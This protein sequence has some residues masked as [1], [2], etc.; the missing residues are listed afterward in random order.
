MGL[1]KRKSHCL[2]RYNAD[3]CGY[4]LAGKCW[5]FWSNS[6]IFP[7][8]IFRSSTIESESFFPFLSVVIS[9]YQRVTYSFV[10][11]FEIT[12]SQSC[13]WTSSAA[14]SALDLVRNF[15]RL[16]WLNFWWKPS[17]RMKKGKLESGNSGKKVTNP[18]QAIAIGLSEAR[19]KGAKVPAAKKGGRKKAAPKKAAAH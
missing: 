2:F 4:F 3:R 8:T 5:I 6:T 16:S 18:K 10:L 1:S 9:L 13:I 19:E 17:N 12:D 11:S 7:L 15:E 14:S